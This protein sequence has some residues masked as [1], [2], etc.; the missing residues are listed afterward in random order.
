MSRI[1]KK[2]GDYVRPNITYTDT[3]TKREIL[4]M[5][6]DFEKINNIDDVPM[7]VYISYIDTTDNKA[8][9]RIGGTLILRKEE[10]I[11]LASGRTNFS[12]QK[13]NKVFFR[14][15]NYIELKKEMEKTILEYKKILTD[16][17]QQIKQLILYIKKLKSKNIET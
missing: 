10:Y 7:G 6:Q 5:L 1:I 14:R 15:L 2:Y 12:V 8:T 13:T 9:F 3:L 17:D 16:K 4:E 11:V